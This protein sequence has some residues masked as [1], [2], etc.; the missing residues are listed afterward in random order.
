[1]LL[2]PTAPSPQCIVV[3]S[4]RL[5]ASCFDEAQQL[6]APPRSWAARC[7][8]PGLVLSDGLRGF[9][10]TTV[11][12]PQSASRWS[13]R[14]IE[15][16]A[17]SPRKASAA[18]GRTV[19]DNHILEPRPRQHGLDGCLRPFP[20]TKHLPRDP[21]VGEDLAGLRRAELVHL[22]RAQR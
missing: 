15:G 1:M 4:L 17:G 11:Q 14:L 20:L 21:I 5:A 10:T 3:A 7:H 16:G 12:L 2:A 8:G 18:R 22:P 19:G 6:A 9:L 13:R